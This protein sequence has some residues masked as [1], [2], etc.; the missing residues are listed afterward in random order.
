MVFT[1]RGIKYDNC[2]IFFK[3]GQTLEKIMSFSR[4]IANIEIKSWK[5]KNISTVDVISISKDKLWSKSI[6]IG[7]KYLH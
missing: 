2:F 6:L 7:N 5:F 1:L 4:K 3:R